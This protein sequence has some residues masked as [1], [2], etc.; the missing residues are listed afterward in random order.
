MVRYGEENGDHAAEL[1]QMCH[2]DILFWI[3]TFVWTYDPRKIDAGMNPIIPFNTYPYQD[4]VLLDLEYACG[5]EPRLID[6]SRDVGASWMILLVY[7]HQILFLIGRN[8]LIVSRN[9]DYVDKTGNTDCLFWKLDFI[10]KYLPDF[11]LPGKVER[12]RNHLAFPE[13]SSVID[14]ET[15]TED[16]GRGGRRTSSLLDEFAAFEIS[17]SYSVMGSI[18]F[19]TNSPFY[20]STTKGKAGAY[21]E[22]KNNEDIRKITISWTLHPEHSRGLYASKDGQVQILDEGYT[23]PPNYPFIMDGKVR[24]M[25]Y[26]DKCRQIK[27]PI[28]IARELDMDDGS[29]TGRWFPEE[30]IVRNEMKY[31]RRP[32]LQGELKF[33]PET[34]EPEHFQEIIGGSLKLWC[35]LDAYESPIVNEDIVCGGDV[36]AGTG[37]SNSCLAFYGKHTGEKYAEFISSS[38]PPHRFGEIA[39]VICRWFKGAQLIWEAQGDGRTF[40]RVV[41]DL[42]YTHVYYHHQNEDSLASNITLKPG[43]YHGQGTKRV[44]LGDYLAALDDELLVN[45]SQAAL[46]ECREFIYNDMGEP[47]HRKEKTNIDSSGARASHGDIVTADSMAWKL[48]KEYRKSVL[49]HSMKEPQEDYVPVGS[50][51]WMIREED[52]NAEM[53]STF[54]FQ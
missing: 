50:M 54:W 5:R 33:N 20:N 28:L 3:N 21:W 1:W 36:S 38:M 4:L 51:E 18:P 12:Y 13:Q 53:E 19:T 31:A 25:Y 47:E 35:R 46:S 9:Q 49:D 37:A 29:A 2:D 32:F 44:M 42:G 15:T 41:M 30:V 48:I 17:D 52:R 27:I 40:G 6:K 34:C 7:M 10:L 11:L 26:D 14:G 39:V 16:I 24:S 43:F 8:F 45:R 22:Q 23:F